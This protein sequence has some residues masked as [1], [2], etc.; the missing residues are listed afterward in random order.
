MTE[1]TPDN[2]PLRERM[3]RV[4]TENEMAKPLHEQFRLDIEDLKTG[5]GDLKVGQAKMEGQLDTLLRANGRKS[6][7]SQVV[8][9]G[10]LVAVI[11]AASAAVVAV[12]EAL[13]F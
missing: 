1:H 12:A 8:N 2:C 6:R 10:G 13:G 7:R 5:V 4:E 9:T 11:V 3:A